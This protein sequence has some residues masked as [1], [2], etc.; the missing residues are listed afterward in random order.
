MA[1][2]SEI[3][4]VTVTCSRVLL[5]MSNIN[6]ILDVGHTRARFKA[7]FTEGSLYFHGALLKRNE[8]Y[9]FIFS[10]SKQREL[11]L[12]AHQSFQL[13]LFEDTSKY[14]VEMPEEMEAV[15]LTYPLALERFDV[16]P[17]GFR[18][19]LIYTLIRIK[20]VQKRVDKALLLCENLKRGN[21]DRKTVFSD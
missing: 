9:E 14:G 19:S 8:N 2:Q 6:Q 11:G 16:L 20:D 10:K 17:E 13:Q 21:R 18:R 5:Q 12:S 15:L 3:F 7:C 1:L 4:E